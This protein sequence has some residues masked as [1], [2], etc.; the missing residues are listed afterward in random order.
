MNDKYT[1]QALRELVTVRRDSELALRMCAGSLAAGPL[2]ELCVQAAAECADAICELEAL[3]ERLGGPRQAHGAV[4]GF[5]RSGWAGL[6]AALARAEDGA[7]LD[8]C[9]RGESWILEA[10]RNALDDHL[11]DFVR[12]AV[13]RQFE[14][15]M[16]THDA[17]RGCR[18]QRPAR[19]DAAAA[20]G[21]QAGQH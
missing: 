20:P 19:G 7:I 12:D 3:V 1:I 8:A 2:R 21:A 10:Y 5:W 11:P 4:V 18:A 6:R 13:L 16:S 9:E 15:L 14:V 17:I